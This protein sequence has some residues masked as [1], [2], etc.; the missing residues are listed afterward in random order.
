VTRRIA[1]CA[2]LVAL[3]IGGSAPA[4]PLP[5]PYP[6]MAYPGY[7]PGLPP[8]EVIAIVR[9]IGLEPLTRPLRTGPSY[10]LRALDP[11]GQE[12]RVVVDARLGR[13]LGVVPVGTH[14]AL[15]PPL[16][17]YG[18][19]LGR[20]APDGYGP[21]SRI[22]GMPPSMDDPLTDGPAGA[23]L[24]PRTP[25]AATTPHPSAQGNPPLPRPR[26]KIATSSA[27]A[28]EKPAPA[29]AAAPT[30]NQ[31]TTESSKPPTPPAATPPAPPTE[32]N[33]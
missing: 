26:P 12:V 4:Q 32:F 10:A 14:H 11:A 30:P 2:G 33:E 8:Y 6:G 28:A 5:P 15:M 7:G 20:L 29:D 17:P 24:L 22:A 3:V 23:M 1:L 27:P 19:P 13:V 16:S 31:A 25:G 9:A 21:N 18:R